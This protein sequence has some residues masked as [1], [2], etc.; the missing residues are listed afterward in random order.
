MNALPPVSISDLLRYWRNTL[1]DE[2][3]MGL[4]ATDSPVRTTTDAVR[5]GNLDETSVKALQRA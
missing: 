1:A 3:L 5:A 4:D 2:D